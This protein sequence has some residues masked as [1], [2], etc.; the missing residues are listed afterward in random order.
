M[1]RDLQ[2]F[3]EE[4]LTPPKLGPHVHKCGFDKDPSRTGCGHEWTHDGRETAQ[5]AS[6]QEYD[7]LHACPKCGR[8]PWKLQVTPQTVEAVER[9]KQEAA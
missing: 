1:T 9:R 4:L 2:D 5:A 3:L 6:D 7:E 8:G